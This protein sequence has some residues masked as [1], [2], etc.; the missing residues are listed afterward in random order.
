MK[1]INLTGE[2]LM[3]AY[4]DHVISKRFALFILDNKV[5]LVWQLTPIFIQ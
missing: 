5:K 2:P 4:G 3:Y 1:D